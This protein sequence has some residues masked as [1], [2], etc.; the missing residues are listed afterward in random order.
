M[1]YTCFQTIAKSKERYMLNEIFKKK[2][3]EI[4]AIN[5]M[6]GWKKKDIEIKVIN[7]RGCIIFRLIHFFVFKQNV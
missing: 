5:Q 4:N 7:Q 6:I 2:D 1:K 3:I